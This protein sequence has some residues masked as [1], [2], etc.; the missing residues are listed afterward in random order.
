MT[1]VES[2]PAEDPVLRKHGCA[3]CSCTF[4]TAQ[5]L[6]VHAFR[7]HGVRAE[8]SFYVQSEVC[9]GCLRTFHT[10]FRV[11]QHL[12]YR[13]NLCWDRI[14]DVRNKDAPALVQL[15]PH[16]AGVC[17]LPA[18]RKHHGPLRPTTRQRTIQKLRK[19]LAALREEGDED[20]AW[21]DPFTA[22]E[23]KEKSQ[24]LLWASL[25]DWFSMSTPTITIVEFHNLFF[26]SMLSMNIEDM[27][28]A[29]LFIHWIETDL[30]DFVPED[31]QVQHMMLL[32]T[33]YMS[34]LEDLRP[35]TIRTRHKEVETHLCSLEQADDVAPRPSRPAVCPRRAR[36]HPIVID[37]AQMDIDEKERRLWRMDRRPQR[38]LTPEQGPFC[39]IHLYAGRRREQDF[40]HHMNHLLHE[41]DQAWTTS[42][43]VISLDTA[44]DPMMNVHSPKLWSWLLAAAKA[45]RILGFLLGPPCETWSS[46]RHEVLLGADGLPLKGPRPLRL[47]DQCWGIEGLSLREL[48]QLSVGTCLLLRGLWLCVPIALSGGAVLLE[49][50][51]PPMQMDRPS[52]FRTGIVTLLL[53]EGWLFRR[54][55]FQQWKH[56][57]HG[58]KPTSLLYANNAIPKVLDELALQSVE[59]PVQTLIGKGDDG[60]FRTTVAKEYPD[61]LCKCFAHAIWRHISGL[62]LRSDGILPTD[63]AKELTTLSSR[64][65]PGKTMLPDYQPTHGWWSIA[66]T[67]RGISKGRGKRYIYKFKFGKR[68]SRACKITVC[69]HFH[70]LIEFLWENSNIMYIHIANKSSNTEWSWIKVL[71]PKNAEDREGHS[72][73]SQPCCTTT[74][75]IWTTW[76][77]WN[78]RLITVMVL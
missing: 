34:L 2:V 11:L 5:Q 53:R 1:L 54:H 40:H 49:H 19:E 6:A 69:S 18:V 62:P 30:T 50:P 41:G 32:E 47:D 46:A 33:A 16:L 65:G 36:Q 4:P 64:V 39:I 21:W 73:L 7:L 68:I 43:T 25:S 35:W 76:L 75:A 42:V 24:K 10:S 57:A 67:P 44:I 17:R 61:N 31:D 52:I 38:S 27:K 9:P 48:S 12:R 78:Q 45:G 3:H 8:E 55:T 13:G 22:P 51:A 70:M 72:S 77:F 23:L 60:L 26:D 37:F 28:A 14:K 66:W 74:L 56:G 71:Y 29:R 15:P 63:F 59:R 58:I 20:F